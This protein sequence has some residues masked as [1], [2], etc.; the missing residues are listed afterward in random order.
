MWNT[1]F[2][3]YLVSN[4]NPLWLRGD[5]PRRWRIMK[6]RSLVTHGALHNHHVAQIEIGVE[7]ASPAARH[8]CGDAKCE[9]LFGRPDGER[10]ADARMQNTHCSSVEGHFEDVIRSNFATQ[11]IAGNECSSLTQFSQEIVE[12]A[13]YRDGSDGLGGMQKGGLYDA[14]LVEVVFDDRQIV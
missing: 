3:E 12:E 9:C 14:R 2:F 10:R 11:G 4:V 13:Q 7:C 1:E 8:Q 5:G 6:T